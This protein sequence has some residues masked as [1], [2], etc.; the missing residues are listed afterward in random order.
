MPKAWRREPLSFGRQHAADGGVAGP[1]RV[2]GEA[3]AV[4]REPSCS[5]ATVH[6]ASTVHGHVAGG[7]LQDAVE[8]AGGED[9]VGRAPADC[10]SRPSSRRRGG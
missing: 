5:A 3:L 10:P 2:E 8:P 9:H 6:P 4:L 7:V 1:E